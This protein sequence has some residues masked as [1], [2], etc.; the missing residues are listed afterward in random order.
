METPEA[1]PTD[2]HWKYPS[3]KYL[4]FIQS[5]QVG[6][7]IATGRTRFTAPD[8][9]LLEGGSAGHGVSTNLHVA[10]PELAPTANHLAG[11]IRGAQFCGQLHLPLPQSR[12]S[13]INGNFTPVIV[14]RGSPATCAASGVLEE[15][16]AKSLC[17]II[18]PRRRPLDQL[19]EPQPRC[20]PCLGRYIT[21][22]ENWGREKEGRSEYGMQ[23]GHVKEP[24]PIHQFKPFKQPTLAEF[25]KSRV[26]AL[27]IESSFQN[28]CEVWRVLVDKTDSSICAKRGVPYPSISITP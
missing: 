27:R 4:K 22:Q 15:K 14:G 21:G 28:R 11:A 10:F 18:K 25:S 13:E 20:Q 23:C 8:P 7:N 19:E 16:P 5:K 1:R 17:L 12:G 9:F 3:L 6:S 26:A 2:L 24:Y